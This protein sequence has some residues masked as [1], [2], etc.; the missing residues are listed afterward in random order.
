MK[1]II[2]G[3]V[4]VDSS[5]P[6]IIEDKL[7][8]TAKKFF[9]AAV[10]G[11]V[12][13]TMQGELVRANIH[14][15]EGTKRGVKIKSNA[16]AGSVYDSFELALARIST[17]LKKYKEKLKEYRR[18][19]AKNKPFEDMVAAQNYYI[20]DEYINDD[21]IDEEFI[22]DYIEDEI[23]NKKTK[24]QKDKLN[25]ITEKNISIETLSV[26]DAIMKMDLISTPA[27]VFKNKDNGRVNVV[28][29]RK[30]RNISWIDIKE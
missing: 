26:Q 14:I 13:F 19:V 9:V 15:N 5:L 29:R 6:K 21:F 8:K 18:E 2:A 23:E 1:V 27:L 28:Y 12:H 20:A 16:E 17:Q 24:V 7:S 22:E 11:I 10:E 25:I 3:N 30:D 4:P